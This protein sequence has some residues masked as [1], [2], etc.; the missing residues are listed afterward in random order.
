MAGHTLSLS[1]PVIVRSRCRRVP[2]KQASARSRSQVRH[3]AN[4]TL[5]GQHSRVQISNVAL[6]HVTTSQLTSLSHPH[7]GD[8]AERARG[9]TLLL[10]LRLRLCDLQCMQ[11]QKSHSQ[12]CTHSTPHSHGLLTKRDAHSHS[13]RETNTVMTAHCYSFP[14]D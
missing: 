7:T 2:S 9:E 13:K 14:S 5:Q 12:Q 3:I 6:H 10:C 8:I 4:Q 11:Q 1:V